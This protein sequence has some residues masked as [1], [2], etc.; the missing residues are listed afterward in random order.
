MK[1]RL[2]LSA[3]LWL[4]VSAAAQEA[5]AIGI[6]APLSGPSEILGRQILAGAEGVSGTSR[7][8]VDTPCTEEAGAEAARRFVDAGVKAV[9]GFVCTPPL[10][11]ALPVLAE[12]GIPVI[13][14]GARSDRVMRRRGEATPAWRTAPGPEAEAE[15][16]AALV[17]ERWG[18]EPYAL[19]EDG[20][21]AARDLA[22]TVRARLDAQGLAPALNDNYRPAE[23]RQFGL[24][25]R[26]AQSGV[27]RALVFGSRN[28]VA[29]VARDA[30]ESGLALEIVSGESL[31]DA[32]AEVPLPAG[33]LAVTALPDA[34]APGGEEAPALEGY[35]LPARTGVEIA[36]EAVRRAEADGR[37]IAEVLDTE[38]FAT[39]SGLVRFDDGR[40]AQTQPFR[41]FRWDGARFVPVAGT[42]G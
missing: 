28:D 8:E 30:A 34:E 39:S 26:L 1:A 6:A 22:D 29:I 20:S 25:R 32:E 4:P 36:L 11:G 35:A 12:A 2:L 18:G 9:V 10:A 27:S 5:P 3:L 7:V 37:T 33:I 19:V 17:R 40:S 38:T 15:A 14:I 13:D 21:P 42:E 24:A 16:I 23:E 41:A 31:F